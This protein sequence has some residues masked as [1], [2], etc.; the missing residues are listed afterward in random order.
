MQKDAKQGTRRSFNFINK[1]SLELLEPLRADL[2]ELH[3]WSKLLLKLQSEKADSNQL[4]KCSESIQSYVC[5]AN[6]AST[7]W[8]T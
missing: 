6:K 2:P 7:S 8:V 1:V 4:I 5:K 3:T